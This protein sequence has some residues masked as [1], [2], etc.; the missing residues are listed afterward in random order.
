VRYNSYV[1]YH[2][3]R[4]TWEEKPSTNEIIARFESRYRWFAYALALSAVKRLNSGRCG[5]V[6]VDGANGDAL[7]E[8]MPAPVAAS[9]TPLEM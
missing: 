5:L 6:V 1:Y 2:G 8:H 3:E 4:T 9:D 7:L